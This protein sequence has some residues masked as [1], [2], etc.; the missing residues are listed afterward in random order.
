[1]NQ[2]VSVTRLLEKFTCVHF[3]LVRLKRMVE[4]SPRI[5]ITFTRVFRKRRMNFFSDNLHSVSPFLHNIVKRL[6][7]CN[8]IFRRYKASWCRQLWAVL[9]RSWITN[10]RDIIIFR[11]RIFQSIVSCFHNLVK[12]MLLL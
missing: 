12:R 9:W 4:K 8:S 7:F 5:F 1:M 3:V 6:H 2:V 10:S 11:I